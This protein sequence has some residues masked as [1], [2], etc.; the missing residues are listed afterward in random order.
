MSDVGP[1]VNSP[2]AGIAVVKQ[3]ERSDQRNKEFVEEYGYNL[4]SDSAGI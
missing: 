4:K 2:S 1:V 3:N